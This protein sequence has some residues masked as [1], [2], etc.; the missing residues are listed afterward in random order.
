MTPEVSPVSDEAVEA[1][2]RAAAIHDDY[3]GCFER[4]DEWEAAGEEYR[5]AYPGERPDSDYEDCEWWR[6]RVRAGLPAALPFLREGIAA[7]ALA[8]VL[9]T[10][11]RLDA[12]HAR[13]DEAKWGAGRAVAV[14]R[15][16]TFDT[17]LSPMRIEARGSC[18]VSRELG[19]QWRNGEH[20]HTVWPEG[21]H[22]CFETEA[23][24]VERA[25]EVRDIWR[26]HP[27]LAPVRAAEVRDEHTH[28]F[29]HDRYELDAGAW[30]TESCRCGVSRA[31]G[32]VGGDG[33]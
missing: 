28:T 25:I 8:P 33:D 12:A 24:A 29:V 6:S 13:S 2:A 3:D 26:E 18:G 16:A 30:P 4:V 7:E 21:E 5:D 1:M 32:E 17:S 23:D 27:H 31:V 20:W 15:A 22:W 11:D 10:L 14:I 19:S 9:A